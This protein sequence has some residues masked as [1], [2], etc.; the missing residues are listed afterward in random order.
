MEKQDI[1]MHH[2]KRN[3][4]LKVLKQALSEASEVQIKI[5]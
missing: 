4:K 2:K 1:S 5:K 3:L